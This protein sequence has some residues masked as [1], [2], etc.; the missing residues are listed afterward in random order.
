M[1]MRLQIIA[2]NDE[3]TSNFNQKV[4]KSNPGIRLLF[5]CVKTTNQTAKEAKA[6]HFRPEFEFNFS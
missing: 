1:K 6:C 4:G 5:A 3:K 2:Q